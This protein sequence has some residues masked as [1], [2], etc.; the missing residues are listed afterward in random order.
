MAWLDKAAPEEPAAPTRD[1]AGEIKFWLGRIKARLDSED[2]KEWSQTKTDAK[3]YYKGKLISDKDAADW[4]GDTV[5]LNMWRRTL[6]YFVDALFSQNPNF[7]VRPRP[8]RDD[9]QTLAGAAAVEDFIRYLWTEMDVDDEARRTLKDAYIGNVAVA[10]WDWDAG[11]SLPRVRWMAGVLVVDPEAHGALNR[12]KWVAEEVSM[13]V[14]NIL[15]DESFPLERR[16]AYAARLGITTADLGSKV[17]EKQKKVYHVHTRE[18]CN[19]VASLDVLGGGKAYG[20]KNKLFTVVEDWDELLNEADDPYPWL[21]SDEFPFALLR[22]DEL[23]GEFIGSPIWQ[24]LHSMVNALNWLMSYHLTDM[25]KKATD[26]IGVN[27]NIIKNPAQLTTRSHMEVVECDGDP[28][29][30]VAPLNI[31]KGDMT[32]LQGAQAVMEWLDRIAGTSEI[33]RGEAST[34]KTAEEARYLQ[35]NS[36]LVLKGPGLAF[37]SFLESCVRLLGLSSL[38]YIPAFSSTVGPDGQVMTKAKGVVQQPS[39][40]PASGQQVMQPV[41]VLQDQPVPPEEAQSLGAVKWADDFGNDFGM[42]LPDTQASMGPMGP[43]LQHPS[44]GKVLRKGVDFFVGPN[45]A[46]AWPQMPLEDVKRDMLLTF[47]AGSTRAG[48]RLDQQQAAKALLDVLGPLYQ[49]AG[50]A[51]QLY[52]LILLMAKSS[53]L[54]DTHRLVPPRAVF[55]QTFQAMMQAQQMAAQQQPASK[56]PA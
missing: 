5:E 37:D 39:V 25:K 40:D 42:R 6:I 32:S 8:G 36:S 50:F 43:V 45:S 54:P 19:P 56:P 38:F 18:G 31:G 27:K 11:R 14:L 49:Q 20:S 48:W 26:L 30:A 17:F 51:D 15:Q 22:I 35:E 29:M 10:K 53:P 4:G 2:Y 52:E 3:N 33:V 7:V 55:V 24:L 21:D 34:R 28:K 9:D 46:S 44:P 16:Q 13:T 41:E 47:E 12:A 23:P 1:I